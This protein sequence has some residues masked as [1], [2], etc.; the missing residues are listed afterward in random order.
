[1]TRLRLPSGLK[2][3]ERVAMCG[4]STVV[5]EVTR[6]VMQDGE[7]IDHK[8]F[9]AKVAMP[10]DDVLLAAG[11]VDDRDQKSSVFEIDAGRVS[12]GLFEWLSRKPVG[13]AV[14]PSPPALPAGLLFDRG[15][16]A[17]Q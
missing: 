4:G 16:E 13:R 7:I 17:Y 12:A 2:Q 14:A 9:H 10:V 8:R 6:Y 11:F 3:E 5:L 1:M 15:A